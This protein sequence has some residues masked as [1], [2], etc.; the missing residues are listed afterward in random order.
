M[1]GEVD[2][3]SGNPGVAGSQMATTLELGDP[4]AAGVPAMSPINQV[5][6]VGDIAVTMDTYSPM[7]T[8]LHS[9]FSLYVP[10]ETSSGRRSLPWGVQPRMPDLRLSEAF[11]PA[12]LPA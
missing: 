3:I 9:Y 11:L 2:S 6:Q 7:Q 5:G 4:A 1:V 10:C 12:Q 8:L